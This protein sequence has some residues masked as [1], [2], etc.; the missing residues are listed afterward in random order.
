[1]ESACRFRC[2]VDGAYFGGWNLL[3][4]HMKRRHGYIATNEKAERFVADPKFHRCLICD[5]KLLQGGHSIQ[6]SRLAKNFRAFQCLSR[7][8]SAN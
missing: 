5:A 2:G 4:S 7:Q 6:L 8:Q 1:M 3:K